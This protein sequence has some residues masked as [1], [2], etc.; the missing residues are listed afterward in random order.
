MGYCLDVPI[1]SVLGLKV[2][3]LQLVTEGAD[4]CKKIF[5]VKY[6]YIV[7]YI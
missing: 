3:N 2:A 5:H 7:S 1:V 6:N 4:C